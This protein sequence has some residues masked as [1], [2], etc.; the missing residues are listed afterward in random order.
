MNNPLNIME[1]SWNISSIGVRINIHGRVVKIRKIPDM[2]VVK[3]V[4]N[5]IINAAVTKSRYSDVIIIAAL[6][7][8]LVLS[9]KFM[10]GN[11]LY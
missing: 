1:S 4:S 10:A 2:G 9:I 3:T 11:L 7:L 6:E 5:M 8:L